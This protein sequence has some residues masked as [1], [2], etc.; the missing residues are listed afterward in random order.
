MG[1]LVIT[2]AVTGSFTTRDNSPCVP[3]TP[4][5]ISS[6]LGTAWVPARPLTIRASVGIRK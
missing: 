6:L 2:A 1:K 5:E 4:R 3:Y